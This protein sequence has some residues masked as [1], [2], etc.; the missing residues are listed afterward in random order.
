MSSPSRAGA[1]LREVWTLVRFSLVGG[2]ATLLHFWVASLLVVAWEASPFL[3][4][5]AGFATAFLFSFVGQ[6]FFAFRSRRRVTATILRFTLVALTAFLASNLVLAGLVQWQAL[7]PLAA[8]LLAACV[9]PAVSFVL[10]RWW[11][12]HPS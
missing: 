9:I 6:H 1:L 8:T 5:A 4:N 7:P 11:V 3:A 12:F 2:G 10:Y